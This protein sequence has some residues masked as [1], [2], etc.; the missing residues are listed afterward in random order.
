MHQE[1]L[2]KYISGKATKQETEEV[3]T[4]IDS[5]PD[6]LKKFMS[7]RKSYDALIWQDADKPCAKTVKK[8]TLQ[9]AMKG[10]MRIAAVFVIA[11]GLSYIVLQVLQE[12]NISMQT[13]SVPAG[14]RTQVTLADG[15]TVWVN[16]KSTLT[17][18]SRFA[19][20]TRNVQL[21]GE[22]YFE[23][24]KDPKKQFIVSTAHQSSI[25]VLGT[26]FNVKAHK[27]A[28]DVI[29][30]LIEGK[31]N[32]EF[33][34]ASHQQEYITMKPGQK[35]VYNSQNRKPQLYTTSGEKEFSWKDGKIIF[36]QTPLRD[37]LNNLAETYNVTFVILKN[38][39]DDDSFS[40]EFINKSL[41]Q[42]LNYIKASS[43]INW[44]YLNNEQTNKEKSKIE[45]FISTNKKP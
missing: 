13:V 10:I 4:W 16:G 14:Q 7:L 44:R 37:A 18:P 9:I 8:R 26:K 25:R 34:N 35:L 5:D 19:S 32:F 42:I 6:N 23:V 24:Q 29:T 17:F 33:N 15:T 43:K 2:L 36:D 12:E 27:D 22:A 21:D 38:V 40:G 39:P 41:E 31:I 1:L 3:V 28:E 11:F 30:T 45:I 20:Q